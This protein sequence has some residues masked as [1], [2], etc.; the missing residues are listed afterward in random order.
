MNK[1]PKIVLCPNNR[2]ETVPCALCGLLWSP[3]DPHMQEYVLEESGAPVCD[4]CAK[5]HASRLVNV[6]FAR[7]SLAKAEAALAEADATYKSAMAKAKDADRT[8][9]AARADSWASDVS[10]TR[11]ALAEA[12]HA[13]ATYKA[14]MA[15]ANAADRARA[16]ART[17]IVES[18][19][20]VASAD[21]WARQ[22][23]IDNAAADA[24]AARAEA[25][26]HDEA[27][28]NYNAAHYTVLADEANVANAALVKAI[29]VAESTKAAAKNEAGPLHRPYRACLAASHT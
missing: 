8:R 14:A 13:D 12:A 28:A 21:H 10:A 16:A 20:A 19:Y 23:A 26:A 2:C 1:E 17:A 5:K 27:V 22:D 29:A 6:N 11:N 4:A 9:A 15:E 3:A 18:N 25:W 7:A 24:H